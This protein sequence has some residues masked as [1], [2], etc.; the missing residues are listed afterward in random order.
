M[1]PRAWTERIRDI[2]DAIAEIQ[3][4]TKDMDFEGFQQDV[5]TLEFTKHGQGCWTNCT[6]SER[7]VFHVRC[8]SITSCAMPL[9]M[10]W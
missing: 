4:F 8:V 5:K 1:S 6:I 3:I 2:L 10:R 7:T 9:H